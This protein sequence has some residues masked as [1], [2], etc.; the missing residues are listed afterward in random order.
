MNGVCYNPVRKGANEDNGLITL[1]PTPE[2]LVIIEKD[3]KMM[4][5]AGFNTIRT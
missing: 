1:N 5:E 3:F 2:D 4:Q